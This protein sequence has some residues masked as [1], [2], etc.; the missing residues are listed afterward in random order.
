MSYQDHL[1]TCPDCQKR[2]KPTIRVKGASSYRRER[3]LSEL[4][5]VI[6]G[7]SYPSISYVSTKT[8]AASSSY[9]EKSQKLKKLG[10]L[11][12]SYRTN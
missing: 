2:Q 5:A 8:K 6:S 12:A 10:R 4:A 9:V 7:V 3:K 11:I 1:R